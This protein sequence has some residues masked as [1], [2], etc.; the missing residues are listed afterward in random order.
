LLLRLAAIVALTAHTALFT[1]YAP[2]HGAEEVAVVAARKSH[3]FA[4]QGLSR[5]TGIST[6]VTAC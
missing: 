2:V 3:H 4:F 1:S 5:D 6:S